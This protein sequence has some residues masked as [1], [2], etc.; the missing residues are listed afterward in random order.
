M[1]G[2]FSIQWEEML[3][4]VNWKTCEQA[5][6]IQRKVIQ[7]VA[8]FWDVAPCKLAIALMLE[9]VSLSETSVNIY[10]TTWR[11]IPEDNHIHNRRC[12][13][14]ESHHR[15]WFNWLTCEFSQVFLLLYLPRNHTLAYVA[16]FIRLDH[17]STLFHPYGSQLQHRLKKLYLLFSVVICIIVYVKH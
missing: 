8:V 17:L 1:Y 9:A 16:K 2:L 14:L 4:V 11:N 6:K 3:R 12:E 15:K 13:N 7:K 5:K 10:Q